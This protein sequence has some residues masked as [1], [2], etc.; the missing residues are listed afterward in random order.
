MAATWTSSEW[1]WSCSDSDRAL[2]VTETETFPMTTP[3]ASHGCGWGPASQTHTH[4]YTHTATHTQLH[5]HTATHTQLHHT[6]SYTHTA[7]HTQLHTHSYTHTP[8]HATARPRGGRDLVTPVCAPVHAARWVWCVAGRA[9]LGIS[10][11]QRAGAWVCRAVSSGHNATPANH[12]Y[13]P[14][15]IA[16]RFPCS[17]CRAAQ[18]GGR[19]SRWWMRTCVHAGEA[20]A[21]VPWRQRRGLRTVCLPFEP[22]PRSPPTQRAGR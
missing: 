11:A 3:C 12:P 20:T 13:V 2:V 17:G 7:T 4:S 8:V 16:G 9:R 6:H 21:A 5:T 10:R 1:M 19:L 18:R 14:V 15:A 22:R